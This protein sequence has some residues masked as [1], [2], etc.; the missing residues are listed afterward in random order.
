ME[1]V[2]LIPRSWMGGD[3]E[4]HITRNFTYFS[5][6]VGNVRRMNNVYSRIKKKKEWGI[7]PDFVQLNSSFGLGMNDLPADLQITFPPDG[8]PP[9]LPSHFIGNL[10]SYYHLSIIMLHRPQFTFM[11]P[12]NIDGRGSHMMICYWSAK[13]LCRLQEAILQSFGMTG[14]L[15][16]Q[17][18]IDF[19]IY[20]ILTCNVL[21][22]VYIVCERSSCLFL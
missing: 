10:H 8:S 17:R 19:T 16:M 2:E 12:T 22:L 14:L 1:S 3:E 6:V 11:E 9:W 21:H 7:D 15:C 13:L 20:C 4:C 18:G 5:R